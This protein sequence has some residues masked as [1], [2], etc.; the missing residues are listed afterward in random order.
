MKLFSLLHPLCLE[1]LS[2][3]S[4]DSGFL[5]CGNEGDSQADGHSACVLG[6]VCV[7]CHGICQ[8]GMAEAQRRRRPLRDS[9]TEKG[10]SPC[11]AEH[12]FDVWELRKCCGGS[13]CWICK[14]SGWPQLF[15]LL[16]TM[17]QH[18]PG[19]M[20]KIL[21]ACAFVRSYPL[22][23]GTNPVKHQWTRG[24]LSNNSHQGQRLNFKGVL[25]FNFSNHN[26]I[27]WA[28]KRGFP[29]GVCMSPSAY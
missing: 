13:I 20:F 24:R 11:R 6:S 16:P 5:C 10:R 23:N 9:W 17:H 18:E 8:A 22:N 21:W 26:Y 4:Y 2:W 27:N 28:K 25:F 15:Q 7:R 12:K 3:V 19:F 29:W 14:G 1:S